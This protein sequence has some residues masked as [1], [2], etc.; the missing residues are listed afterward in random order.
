M[1]PHFNKN[2]HFLFLRV[3]ILK[4]LKRAKKC[5]G[6]GKKEIVI[7][8]RV[9][10]K[11]ISKRKQKMSEPDFK[12][13]IMVIDDMPV[14]LKILSKFFE[15]NGYHVRTFTKAKLAISAALSVPPDLIIL[16]INM[17]EMDGYEAC[18]HLKQN[19]DLKDIPVIFIN[20]ASET[21]DKEMAF[22]CGGV[23]YI[24]N[25]FQ[26]EEAISRVEAHLKIKQ[27]QAELAKHSQIE[28]ETE[29]AY[30]VVSE[31][32]EQIL[33]DKE[34]LLQA[35]IATIVALS[36]LA[37]ARDDETGKHIERVQIFCKLLSAKLTEKAKFK[38]VIDESFINNMYYVSPLHDIGK[39]AVPDAI[40]LKPGKLT[41]KEFD[42]MK[43]H[44]VVGAETLRQIEGNY[45]NN[46]FLKMGI[47]ITRSHHEKWDGTGY[48][49]KLSGENI[50]ISARIMAV[51]DVYDAV[52]SKRCYK[53]AY[54]H[55]ET[56]TIMTKYRGNYLDPD[57]LDA[58]ME[59][60]K[61]IRIIRD[62]M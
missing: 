18:R 30:T 1:N 34:E 50:P 48:P 17:P 33:K 58:F 26:Y 44:T 19:D 7:K 24:T 20:A 43:N 41:Q 14:N 31:Q 4:Y 28:K 13:D 22:I 9:A 21:F 25:P 52:R 27:Y 37:E 23:D 15:G 60:E 42:I 62:E 38:D 51:A 35:H 59:I 11:T 29:K 6:A 47:E 57:I 5:C 2:F 36:K 49:D 3:K 45:K 39:V 61:D 53:R 32:V 56:L 12:A 8:Y 16:D 10:I 54:S 55:N 46:L 40:L